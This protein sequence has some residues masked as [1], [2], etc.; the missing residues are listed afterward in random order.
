MD[1]RK[2]KDQQLVNMIFNLSYLIDA[3]YV[4]FNNNM[5]SIV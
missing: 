3:A 2:K 4:Q 1:K 5:S